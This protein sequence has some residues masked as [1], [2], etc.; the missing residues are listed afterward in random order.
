MLT[1]DV[2]IEI[3]DELNET[4]GSS[5]YLP[6]EYLFSDGVHHVKAFGKI[7]YDS[8]NCDAT[9]PNTIK[10]LA[11]RVLNLYVLSPIWKQQVECMQDDL[12]H[13]LANESNSLKGSVRDYF[14][15]ELSQL[16]GD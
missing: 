14:E 1:P 3:V 9:S 12:S 2:F 13:M 6:A 16:K 11:Y 8:S 5:H 10:H 4:Y 7:I 15:E